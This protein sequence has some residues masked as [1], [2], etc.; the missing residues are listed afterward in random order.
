M[1]VGDDESKAGTWIGE[2]LGRDH[3]L[4]RGDDSAEY[5]DRP[6]SVIHFEDVKAI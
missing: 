3:S 6:E 5:G 2:Q 1:F 4:Y